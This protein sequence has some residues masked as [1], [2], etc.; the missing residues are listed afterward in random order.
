MEL[1]AIWWPI[2]IKIM[3]LRS[4]TFVRD[5]PIPGVRT[6]QSIELRIDCD[7]ETSKRSHLN[8]F[9]Y[10]LTNHLSLFT[11]FLPPSPAVQPQEKVYPPFWSVGSFLLLF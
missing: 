3:L 1:A 11:A 6:R 4:V 2:A 8:W 5:T 7:G 10:L 9:S